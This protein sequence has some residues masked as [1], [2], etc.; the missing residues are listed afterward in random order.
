MKR[1]DKKAKNCINDSL[2]KSLVELNAF[3]WKARIPTKEELEEDRLVREIYA[4]SQKKLNSYSEYDVYLAISQEY[5]LDYVLPLAI[6]LLENNLLIDCV[7]YEG[8]LLYAVLSINKEYWQTNKESYN[9]IRTIIMSE[10]NRE[11]F[12]EADTPGKL[13]RLYE[14]LISYN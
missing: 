13:K 10:S 4:L 12:E 9:Q 7:F 8:D 5:G 14:A 6:E 3:A 2:N 11:K 1:H